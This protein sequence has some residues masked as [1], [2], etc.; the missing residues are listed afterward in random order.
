MRALNTTRATLVLIIINVAVHVLR[1]YLGGTFLFDYGF[2]P[3]L[4]V[5]P[6]GWPTLPDDLHT[7]LSPVSYT[8]L[9]GD[10]MHLGMNM[11]FLLAFGTPVE[12][13]LGAGRFLAFYFAC[14]ILAAAAS[15][16]SYWFTG[17]VV[18]IVGASGAIAGLFG[19]TVRFARFRLRGGTPETPGRPVSP[20][21]LVIS[22]VVINLIIGWIGFGNFAVAWQAHLGGFFAGLLLYGLFEPRRRRGPR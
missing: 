6:F 4:F 8:F 5:E 13:R 12:R 7:W 1:D 20:W 10:W 2:I 16:L 22:F 3:A 19:A 9:H 15:A 21:V 11:L 18:L 17:G 14:G